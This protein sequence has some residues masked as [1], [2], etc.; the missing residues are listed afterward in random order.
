MKRAGAETVQGLV[1]VAVALLAPPWGEQHGHCFCNERGWAQSAAVGSFSFTTDIK[2]DRTLQLP[3]GPPMGR[4]TV[5]ITSAEEA[6]PTVR[7]HLI[8]GSTLDP[9][10]FTPA[11]LRFAGA[12]QAGGAS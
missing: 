11:A 6:A 2:E 7:R 3:A 9:T 4:R 8:Y 10:S 12:G 1:A 5:G